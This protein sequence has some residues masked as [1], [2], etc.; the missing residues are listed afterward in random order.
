MTERIE[1]VF[2]DEVLDTEVSEEA[3][4]SSPSR[5]WKETSMAPGL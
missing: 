4:T 3:A 5:R 2:C 1:Y